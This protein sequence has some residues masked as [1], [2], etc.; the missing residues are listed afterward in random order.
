MGL[1]QVAGG[2]EKEAEFSLRSGE[3]LANDYFPEVAAAKTDIK[4]K[5]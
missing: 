1:K 2:G 3:K 4:T 5:T